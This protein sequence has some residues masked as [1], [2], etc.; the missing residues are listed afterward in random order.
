M[1]QIVCLSLEAFNNKHL[2]SNL[3]ESDANRGDHVLEQERG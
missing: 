1:G 3:L 2:E